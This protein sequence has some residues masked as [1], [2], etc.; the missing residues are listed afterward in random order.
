MIKQINFWI[1]AVVGLVLS[2]ATMASESSLYDFSWLDK[3]KE[4]Y[5]LQNRK[6]HK[7]GTMNLAL[8]FG[9]T[10][11]GPFV[12]ATA[13]QGRVGF[14]PLEDWGAELIFSYNSGKENENAKGVRAQSDGGGSAPFRRITQGYLGGMIQWSPFYAK[15]NTFN[16][17]IYVDWYIGLGF[18]KLDE[19]NNRLELKTSGDPEVDKTEVKESHN[20]ILWGTGLRVFLSNRWH[21]RLDLA[22][23]HYSATK[24]A[25]IVQNS[26]SKT[27]YNNYDLALSI[28]MSI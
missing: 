18:A 5:V 6:F 2:T 23:I 10:V 25:A 1:M 21:A 13:I 20:G 27:Y 24:A 3:D 12:D 22:G 17:I 14:Y 15:V 11:S 4:V 16:K 28:G 26:S 8:G 9:M 19:K 7:K